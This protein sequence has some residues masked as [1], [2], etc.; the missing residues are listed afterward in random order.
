MDHLEAKYLHRN[1]THK[2]D[3][4]QEKE[5]EKYLNNF[6]SGLLIIRLVLT[7]LMVVLKRLSQGKGQDDKTWINLGIKIYALSIH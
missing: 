7:W 6:G 4:V 5:P 1:T 3:Q 2:W